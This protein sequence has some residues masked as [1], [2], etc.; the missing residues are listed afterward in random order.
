MAASGGGGGW[1][2]HASGDGDEVGVADVASVADAAE[3]R[4]LADAAWAA[5]RPD[6]AAEFLLLAQKRDASP[7]QWS[8]RRRA[9]LVQRD[10]AAMRALAREAARL[11]AA[12]S[13][14]A[15]AA[16]RADGG[17]EVIRRR[18]LPELVPASQH[19]ARNTS[20]LDLYRGYEPNTFSVVTVSLILSNA[21][22]TRASR[23]W[24]S[25]SSKK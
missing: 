18:R 8:S 17:R 16:A 11:T 7:V 12:A 24:P 15:P 20:Y 13:A 1:G 5:R 4:W 14:A 21:R 19:R 3:L 9:Q 22:P 23:R 6:D 10:A 25:R 2:A